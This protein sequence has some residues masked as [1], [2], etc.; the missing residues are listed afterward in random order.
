MYTL[1]LTISSK[2]KKKSIYVRSRDGCGNS[3]LP[4]STNLLREVLLK[5]VLVKG[6]NAPSS[7]KNRSL[8]LQ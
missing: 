3:M 8:K 4:P 6:E 5:T 7:M 2:K 1:S